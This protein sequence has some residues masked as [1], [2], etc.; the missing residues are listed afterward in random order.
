M[1][2]AIKN[3]TQVENDFAE[4]FNKNRHKTRSILYT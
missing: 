1:L 3:L 4:K 2:V